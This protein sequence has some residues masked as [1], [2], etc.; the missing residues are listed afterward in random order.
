MYKIDRIH[1]KKNT[2]IGAYADNYAHLAKNLYNAALFLLRNNYTAF[3]K[4]NLTPNEISVREELAGCGIEPKRYLSYF[5]LEKVMRKTSNPD[6]FSGLPMQTAQQELRRAADDFSN[7]I[8]ALNAWYKD[9][10][11][12]LGKPKMPGYKKADI[13]AFKFTNQDA[14]LRNGRLK[15]P[16]TKL[17]LKTPL[18][19]ERRLKEV[20][21]TPEY[22]GFDFLLVYELPD[23]SPAKGSHA[24]AID[25]GVNNI[26]TIVSDEGTSAIFKIR[27]EKAENQ[28]FNKEK[29]RL[30]SA[31]TKGHSQMSVKSNE[32]SRL[33]N[34][35][36]LFLRDCQHKIAKRV[37]EFCLAN[38]VGTLALGYNK[39]QKQRSDMGKSNN[40]AFVMLPIAGLMNTISEKATASGIKVVMQEE[41]YTSKASFLDHDEIPVYGNECGT[42]VFSGSRIHRGLYRAKDGTLL[43]ADIN[44]AANILRKAGFDTSGIDKSRLQVPFVIGFRDL[45]NKCIP[46][47]RIVA[48]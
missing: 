26:V 22:D 24:A 11:K 35:R 44:A 30:S 23:P 2:P 25:F 42:P 4:E 40:Q 15:L 45:N 19:E 48:A 14:V 17:T 16:R 12:F 3:G 29:A 6:F 7:W 43:N 27:P 9:P 8:K 18:R 47:K 39:G 28:F 36:K 10:S 33:S 5:T 32:L 20:I 31:L 38:E 37:V 46:L 13:T 34:H 1:V 41:S 21:V